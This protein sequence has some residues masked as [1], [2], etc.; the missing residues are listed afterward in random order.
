MTPPLA[1]DAGGTLVVRDQRISWVTAGVAR[2][3]GRA[4]SEVVGL[5][6]TDLVVPEDQARLLERYARRLAGEP[7]PLELE[8]TLVR[9]DGTRVP[10]E[11]RVA[12]E[13]EE[14]VVQ[15]RDA[16]ALVARRPRLS[17]VAELGVAI[18]RERGE[19]GVLARVRSGLAAAGLWSILVRVEGGGLTVEWAELP[20]EALDAFRARSGRD[21]EGLDG[22]WSP[23]ARKIWGEGAAYTD[24]WGA[25]AGSF[26]MPDASEAVRRFATRLGLSRAVGVRLD[27]RE[28]PRFYLVLLGEWLRPEDVAAARLFGSQIAAALD[29]ARVISDLSARNAELAALSRLGGLASDST[30]LAAFFAAALGI[31]REVVGCD[32]AAVWIFDPSTG[33]LVLVHGVG[34]DAAQR[35]AH[36]RLPAGHPLVA[37]LS[38]RNAFTAEVGDTGPFG[39]AVAAAGMGSGAWVP[40]SSHSR[41][42]GA[43]AV[44]YG[45]PGLAAGRLE[46]LAAAGAHVAGAIATH[47]LLED[48]RRRVGELTL[49]NELARQVFRSEPGD[50]AG[51]LDAG[52]RQVAQALQADAACALL[53]SEDGVHLRPGGAHGAPYPGFRE[54]VALEESSLAGEAIRTGRAVVSPDA[55]R[56]ARASTRLREA[57]PPLA[58]LT[59]PLTGRHATR[60]VVL[61]ASH[62]GRAWADGDLAVA[63]ALA[64]QLAVGLENAELYAEARRRADELSVAHRELGHAQRQLLQR[65]RLAA[66][67]ELAAVVAHEVRNPLGVIFNSVGSLRRLVR[68]E[69]DA[70]LLLDIVGEEAERLNRIVGDLLDFARPSTPQLVPGPL[71]QVVEEAVA[72]AVGAVPGVRVETAFDP[73]LPPVPM[74]ERLVRQA[75]LNLAS[76]AAQAMPQGGVLRVRVRRDGG[77]AV[78]ELEDEGPGVPEDVRARIFEPFFT[79]KASGTGLGL[80]VVKRIVDGHGAEIAVRAA[81]SGG[82]LFALRFPL[83]EVES[84][85]PITVQSRP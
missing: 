39:D 76:N 23:F 34:G 33:E 46:V 22:A 81:P 17:A 64:G 5:R 14:F 85:A 10:V 73:G 60:G 41:P 65:E 35:R 1:V 50:V 82:A 55:S 49:F 8:T 59:L 47:R 57:R 72:S 61:V 56:D 7:I 69:G 29:A 6:F 19:A 79:T 18:Q 77:A 84:A 9:P 32:A 21:L 12:L 16:T 36:A 83:A 11:A 28:A 4:A 74:D 25:S 15:L 53:L 71:A 75:V 26:V 48:L 78:L 37:A 2:L 38:Q 68:P 24:D 30:D 43:L 52:C 58:V 20:R 62:A 31:V 13:G 44:A 67:G 63:T 51:L 70:R 54:A 3:L 80:A 66:L 40:L 27:E 45:R 42:I